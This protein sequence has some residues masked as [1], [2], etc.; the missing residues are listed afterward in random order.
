MPLSSVFQKVAIGSSLIGL[1]FSSPLRAQEVSSPPPI[2]MF[3]FSPA[4]Q[5]QL[6]DHVP[7]HY[8]SPTVKYELKEGSQYTFSAKGIREN[9]SVVDRY[10]QDGIPKGID[11]KEDTKLIKDE[12]GLVAYLWNTFHLRRADFSQS[13]RTRR[14]DAVDHY[15]TR[16]S[17]EEAFKFRVGGDVMVKK[18][19]EREGM[20]GYKNVLDIGFSLSSVEKAFSGRIPKG[21]F[22][23]SYTF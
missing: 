4:P 14:E 22:K 17:R 11:W 10:D 7:V 1:L 15:G 12:T 21:E 6:E 23:I 13:F 5:T 18:T 9:F 2:S 8:E 20:H 19:V 3:S 16:E